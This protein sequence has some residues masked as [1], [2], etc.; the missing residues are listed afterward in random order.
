M[1]RIPWHPGRVT[2]SPRSTAACG[3]SPS[4]WTRSAPSP[5]ACWIGTGSV[6]EAEPQAGLS[7]LI[8]HM[9]FRGTDR[10][11]SAGDRP[12]LRRDGR[13]AQRRH[14]Q[15]DHL[16]LRPR[17]G[18]HL[19][20][21]LDVMAD[22]VWR[23]K[24]DPSDLDA[25]REIVIEEIAM[26][27]DD[28][29]DKVFDVLGEAVFGTH[30]LGRAIIGTADVVG[31]VDAGAAARLPRRALRALERRRGR[32]GLRR[33]RRA[34]RA[35]PPRRRRAQR[36][37]R[38]RRRRPRRRRRPARCAS[39]RKDTEQYHVCLGAPGPRPRRRPPLR[40]ARA[41]QRP[42]RHVVLAAVPGGA[43]EAR[44]GLLGL[45]LPVALRRHRPDRP[46]PRHPPRQRR[47]RRCGVVG[48]ELDRLRAD[49]ATRRRARPGQG[50]RQGPRGARARVD[51]RA[52]E[53]AGL[54]GARRACRCSSVD[55]VDRRASTP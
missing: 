11:A 38:A 5:S 23:P 22:M 7:H 50:E 45:Q 39:S 19:D 9:L 46:V 42:R 24:F 20:R 18:R 6:G 4:A 28:P 31:S 17:A 51:D 37:D 49:P 44:P 10:Y 15:G 40:A 13:R 26:Y 53:P 33:P 27:D 14:R 55:E 43:R 54:V 12:A 8:E 3:S 30:P 2:G 29:Q 52:H 32:R 21:A 1:P 16:G 25:E 34:R 48:D 35:G 36:R 41:R 47:R